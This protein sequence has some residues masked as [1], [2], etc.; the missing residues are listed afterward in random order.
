MPWMMCVK[1]IQKCCMKSGYAAGMEM[2][3]FNFFSSFEMTIAAQM[4]KDRIA[5]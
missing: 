2:V 5:E 4:L 1:P 3:C